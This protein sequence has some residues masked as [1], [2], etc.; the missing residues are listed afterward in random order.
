MVNHD[1]GRLPVIDRANRRVIGMITRSDLLVARRHRL[2]EM[3]EADAGCSGDRRV[4]IVVVND[5]SRPRG[6]R[7]G[8]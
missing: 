1:I 4:L 5:A 6:R 7:C 8:G 2:R 3:R